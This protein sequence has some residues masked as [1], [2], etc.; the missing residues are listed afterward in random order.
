MNTHLPILSHILKEMNNERHLSKTEQM[1][2]VLARFPEDQRK[3]VELYHN[4]IHYDHE[5]CN[6]DTIIVTIITSIIPR[7]RYVL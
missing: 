7:A 5:H 4:M 2:Y 6:K 3:K 1:H